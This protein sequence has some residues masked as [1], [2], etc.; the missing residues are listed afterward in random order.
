MCTIQ[1]PKSQTGRVKTSAARG[2]N[3]IPL[4][5]RR[6]QSWTQTWG[7]HTQLSS[8]EAFTSHLTDWQACP[9]LTAETS[10]QWLLSQN[11]KSV[12]MLVWFLP[13]NH[14]LS[15]STRC[16]SL[17]LCWAYIKLL[18]LHFVGGGGKELCCCLLQYSKVCRAVCCRDETQHLVEDIITS[19]CLSRA[20]NTGYSKTWVTKSRRAVSR[21]VTHT[22]VSCYFKGL[23]NKRKKKKGTGKKW[24]LNLCQSTVSTEVV[25]TLICSSQGWRDM[26]WEVVK[27]SNCAGVLYFHWGLTS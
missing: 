12:A 11:A 26:F 10:Q 2:N 25:E 16:G 8:E 9:L 27:P 21:W 24:I 1:W 3:C 23:Q 4:T 5:Q 14:S 20:Q 6:V 18:S 22:Y 7:R 13:W 17:A 19:H 15:G